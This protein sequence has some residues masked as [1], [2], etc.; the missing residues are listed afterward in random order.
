LY[1]KGVHPH[2]RVS[3]HNQYDQYL[4]SEVLPML[5]QWSGADRI[6]VTGCSFG[7]YHSVNYTLRHPDLIHTCVSMGG[8]FDMHP[9]L[10]G[11]FGEDAYFNSPPDSLPNLHD[12]WYLSRYR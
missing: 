11:Y 2:V 3:R 4:T 1:N 5:R 12:D 8:A 10:S 7:G 9:F 6:A